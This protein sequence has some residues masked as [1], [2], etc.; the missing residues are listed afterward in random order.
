[1]EGNDMTSRRRALLGMLVLGTGLSAQAALEKATETTRPALREPLASLPLRL[2][3]WV[4]QAEPMN[5]E[6]LDRTQATDYLNRVYENTERP[7]RPLKLWINYSETGLNL[8]HSP[9]VCLPSG[10]WNKVEA[11]CRVIDLE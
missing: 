8:R 1:M 7:G 3:S 11:Q 6:I 5:K 2:G 9:E 10:G 4:G